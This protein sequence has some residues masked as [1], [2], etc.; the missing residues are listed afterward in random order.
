MIGKVVDL[1][2]AL[3]NIETESKVRVLEVELENNKRVKLPRANVEIIE[4]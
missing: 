3:E 4:E 1:P 2:V